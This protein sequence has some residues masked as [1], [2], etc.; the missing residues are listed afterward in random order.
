MTTQQDGGERASLEFGARWKNREY[1]PSPSEASR[2]LFAG[3]RARMR[4]EAITAYLFL[5]PAL[6]IIFVFGLWPVAHA[7]YVSLHKWNIKPRG[8]QC[9]P[10]WLASL[11]IGSA[12]VSE[13]TD[14]LGS[15]NYV[16]LLGL[17]NV[18]AVGLLI[19]AL[20]AAAVAFALLRRAARTSSGNLAYRIAGV[21]V[22]VGAIA[23]LALAL[24]GLIESGEWT[25]LVT[26]GLLLASWLIWRGVDRTD[27]T[28]RL[29][30][31]L[32]GVSTLLAAGAFFFFIDFQ[33]MWELGN[34]ALFKS[35][36]Y[37]VFYSAGTVPVQLGLSLALAYVLFQG[38]KGQ[39]LFRLLYFLPYIAPSVATAVVFKRIFSLRDTGL[40]NKFITTLGMEPLKW[41]NEARP[42][43]VILVDVINQVFGT[44]LS[45]PQLPDPLGIVLAGP[46]LALVSII[47]YNWWVFVGY[48]T[49]I[50]LAGLGSIPGE[51]Y[52]AA[53]I[54]GA[55]RW[56]LF[57]RITIPLLSPT[58]F[59][60][61]V[62]ATIGTFKAF[63]HI[64][65]MQEQAARDTVDTASV[66]I[67]RT[68]HQDGQFGEAAAMA[69]ILFGII[70]ILSQIQNRIGERMV[71]YG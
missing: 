64:W 35:L 56:S 22:A 21:I 3:R 37:T 1:G 32:A 50:Y 54:D 14:C 8:L 23:F 24:P 17:Q 55:G 10:Y 4:R 34:Q 43:N 41:L 70:L 53:Q 18:S 47:I 11:N 15:Q 19:A 31:R 13:G 36:I 5:L 68:F 44:S 9:L 38:V 51:L 42:V 12:A 28:L 40:M 52:E 48:D 61:T 49:V 66:L 62:I 39:G 7:L 65:I 20:A 60:L 71:F 59:F 46:S 27:S 6:V 58:T 25:Y 29:I 30:L 16:D 45:W 33:R 2:R 67:F 63:N 26:I 69:F 57:R